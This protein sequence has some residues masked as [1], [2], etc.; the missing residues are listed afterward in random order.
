MTAWPPARG[1][2]WLAADRWP[3]TGLAPGI[4]GG[5]LVVVLWGTARESPD[6]YTCWWQGEVLAPA[7]KRFIRAVEGD[8][9]PADHPQIC[10]SSAG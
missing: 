9:I 2:L 4:E 7:G 3:P 10:A 1:Q 8:L 5:D 6:G